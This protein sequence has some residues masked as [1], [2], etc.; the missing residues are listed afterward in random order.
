MEPG[1]FLVNSGFAGPEP[2][3][4]DE[5]PNDPF[6]VL[7]T[8]VTNPLPV[9]LRAEGTASYYFDHSLA[10]A[11]GTRE[12]YFEGM[13]AEGENL[14]AFD[15]ENALLLANFIHKKAVRWTVVIQGKAGPGVQE[16]E[17]AENAIVA[18]TGLAEWE[19]ECDH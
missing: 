2:N 11:E 19:F 18:K 14:P 7:D 17:Q 13:F 5:M 8:G 9:S 12:L 16:G 4:C 6:G 15:D 10:G 1:T 3:D